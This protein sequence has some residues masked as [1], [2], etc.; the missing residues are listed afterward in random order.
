MFGDLHPVDRCFSLYALQFNIVHPSYPGQNVDPPPLERGREVQARESE[1]DADG[2]SPKGYSRGNNWAWLKVIFLSVLVTL[3]FLTF[4]RH[5]FVID[6]ALSEKV[7]LTY[8]HDHQFQFGT[9]LVFT[10]A[11]LGFLTSRYYFP[12]TA[13]LRMVVDALVGLIVS[14]GVCRLSLKFSHRSWQLF[15]VGLFVFLA[16]NIDP[17]SDLLIY[18]GLFTWALLCW[19]ETAFPQAL[20]AG[21][22]IVLA[23]LGVLIKANFLFVTVCTLSSLF[24]LLLLQKQP[25]TAVALVV[26]FPI[27]FLGAWRLAGQHWGN[28]ASFFSRTLSIV[29]GY[30]QTV[31]LIGFPALTSRGLLMVLLAVTAMVL[32]VSA[33]KLPGVPR[34][35][36]GLWFFSFLFVVWK[37]GFVRADLYHMGFCF[38]FVPMLALGLEVIPCEHHLFRRRAAQCLALACCLISLLTLESFFFSSIAGSLAQ[39]FRG[40]REN[41]STLL[42]PGQYQKEMLAWLEEARRATQL[43]NLRERI[44]ESTVDVFGQD[45]CYAVFNQLN[46]H[47]RPVFQSYMAYNEPLMKLNEQFYSGPTAPRFVLFGLNAIDRK[48][49][50]LEDARLLWHLL[51]NYRP[52]A[53]EGPFLLLQSNTTSS[54]AST[55]VRE[56]SVRPGERI[57]WTES[58]NSEQDLWLEIELAP[59]WR[60]RIR[61]IMFKPPRIRIAFWSENSKAPLARM[62]AAAPMLAAGFLASPVLIRNE[63]VLAYYSG[64]PVVR[65]SA[66]SLELEPGTEAFWQSSIRFRLF[67]GERGGDPNRDQAISPAIDKGNPIPP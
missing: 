61:Q 42:K 47:P 51:R 63:D 39:P 41:L 1:S 24:L 33:A 59:T 12:Q 43:P 16:S 34:L 38:G 29:Q 36:L 52:L 22:F 62:G 18:I 17:R 58:E 54:A 35:I 14:M 64:R 32:R 5:P 6:D 67:R 23:V 31:G 10:Y 45:Q 4:P 60:G 28:L 3:T 37:H 30:D 40:A 2:C 56:G 15:S 49:P 13:G 53:A 19:C 55:L 65:P 50:P 46:Y 66:C 21:C 7:V 20:A 57:R 26:A 25:Q 27:A 11:P 9:D 44:K 8:A 48:F